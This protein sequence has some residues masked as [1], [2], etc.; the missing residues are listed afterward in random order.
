M[1]ASRSAHEL[2][3]VRLHYVRVGHVQRGVE[4]VQDRPK[5][6]SEEHCKHCREVAT[7]LGPTVETV[8]E[9]ERGENRLATV[10]NGTQHCEF[11]RASQE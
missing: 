2:L 7:R 5:G 8:E 11:V 9:S 10:G 6:G 1:E 4:T 3:F